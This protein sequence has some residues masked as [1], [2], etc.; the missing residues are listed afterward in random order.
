MWIDDVDNHH[1]GSANGPV[2]P[3]QVRE[4]APQADSPGLGWRKVYSRTVGCIQMLY[5]VVVGWLAFGEITCL[6]HNIVHYGESIG[7]GSRPIS[8]HPGDLIAFA[9]ALLLSLTSLIGG[10]GLLRLRPWARRW[11][12]AY[13]GAVL[14]AVAISMV[15]M[16]SGAIRMPRDFDDLTLLVL[17]AMAFALP[18]LPFLLSRWSDFVLPPQWNAPSES[19]VNDQNGIASESLFLDPLQE[20]RSLP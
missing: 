8:P 19:V 6:V 10:Y 20:K 4:S 2:I 18:Y 15:A 1:Y 14:V 9:T 5:A 16:L 7:K 12:M 3:V 13:L 11:E 17:I